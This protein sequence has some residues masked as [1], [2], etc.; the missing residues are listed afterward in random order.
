MMTGI[1][2]E[3]NLWTAYLLTIFFVVAGFAVY[4][5]LYRRVPD[6]ALVF[7][8]PLAALAP[9]L[10]GYFLLNHGLPPL[11]LWPVAT[12][13]LVGALL[14]FCIPLAAA[15]ATNGT[16][17]GGGDIKFCGILGLVYGPSGMALVFLTA[18]VTAMP[19]IFLLRRLYRTGQPLLFGLQALCMDLLHRPE[20]NSC[21][22][23]TDGRPAMPMSV[24]MSAHCS[25]WGHWRMAICATNA[26]WP[27]VP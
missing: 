15:L 4:D 3:N 6:R 24:L 27:I 14:G 16:G 17:L 10:Q 12:H 23:A 2:I 8:I 22:S 1:P 13:A 9:V 20:E 7:F 11:F 19:V 21:M 25:P 18:A 26:F 5:V